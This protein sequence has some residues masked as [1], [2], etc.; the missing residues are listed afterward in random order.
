[1]AFVVVAA[2]AVSALGF[3]GNKFVDITKLN[4]A[5]TEKNGNNPSDVVFV[6]HKLPCEYKIIEDV[7]V[8]G[9]SGESRQ[10]TRYFVSGTIFR[11]VFEDMDDN[12]VQEI[13]V[14][15]DQRLKDTKTDKVFVAYYAGATVM[16]ETEN[17]MLEEKE[18]SDQIDEYL[19]F[20]F[21]ESEFYNVT[22]GTLNGIPCSVYYSY[23][24]DQDV[25]IFMY[26]NMSNYVLALNYTF[27]EDKTVQT[28]LFQYEAT[29]NLNEFIFNKQLFG[30]CNDTRAFIAPKQSP[31][32]NNKETAVTA[33]VT[34]TVLLC[35]IATTVLFLM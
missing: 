32:K 34:L 22:N 20:F 16:N 25:D 5:L 21:T 24:A 17:I 29:V 10:A 6:P 28:V 23:D 8:T 2:I 13:V 3:K 7:H 27:R 31:C 15:S 30:D 4:K 35:A 12:S 19:G 26:A 33:T 9:P 18:G 11:V 1:L 14:R